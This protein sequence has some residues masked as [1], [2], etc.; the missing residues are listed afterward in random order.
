MARRLKERKILKQQPNRKR[1]IKTSEEA[2][3]TEACKNHTN[4]Q[5]SHL[6]CM[7]FVGI[8]Q[9]IY[10]YAKKKTLQFKRIADTINLSLV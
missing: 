10:E 4:V 1:N 7:H 6:I 5:L 2:Q 8:K 9:S 3:Y